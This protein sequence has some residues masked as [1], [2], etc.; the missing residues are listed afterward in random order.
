MRRL[1]FLL[2]IISLFSCGDNKRTQEPKEPLTYESRE[3]NFKS[4]QGEV[5]L[6]GTLTTPTKDSLKT[7]VIL[8]SG[9]GPDDRD[10]KNQF[11]HKPFLVLSHYL[12]R[13]GI[14][15]LRYDERGVGK[16][17]GNYREA[18]YENLVSD[19]VGA[20]NY[21]RDMGF[22]KVGLIGHS[23]GGGLAPVVSLQVKSDFLILMAPGNDT[24]DRTLVYQ[25][26]ELLKNMGVSENTRGEII[27]T[28]NS[29]LAIAKSESDLGSAKAKMENVITQKNQSATE[30]YKNTTQRLG[31][32]NRLIEGFLD[33]KFI[34]RL[35]NDPKE[36]FK[37]IR[38]PVLVLY[39]DE[40]G[41]VDVNSN[42]ALI[43]NALD[44]TQHEIKVFPGLGHLL[45]NAKGVPME[46]L[47]EIDETIAPEVLTTIS[48]WILK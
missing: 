10:Y 9:S 33:H 27:E 36:T 1:S 31:D 40:D 3:I 11:G 17:T 32:P 21:L 46:N 28:V 22:E 14:T 5:T 23:E 24:A 12:T 6:T 13:K 44:S 38:I 34:Y 29:L 47:H 42:L 41:L 2:V 45:M 43:E 35:K 7:A 30:D 8:I 15:V 26:S 48:N 20:I 19:V 16:S 37:K 18:T 39:G 25:T 4:Q